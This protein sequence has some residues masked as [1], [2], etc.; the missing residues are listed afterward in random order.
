MRLSLGM[1]MQTAEV[2]RWK[3]VEDANCYYYRG[4]AQHEIFS[5]AFKLQW[6]RKACDAAIS[7][8][9]GAEDVELLAYSTLNSVKAGFIIRAKTRTTSPALG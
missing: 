6:D 4:R 8:V 3:G 7:A 9:E 5:N 1:G 2:Y